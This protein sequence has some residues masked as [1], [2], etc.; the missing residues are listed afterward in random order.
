MHIYIYI[1]R[2]CA[3]LN[4]PISQSERSERSGRGADGHRCRSGRRGVASD[5]EGLR[6]FLSLAAAQASGASDCRM[7][8]PVKPKATR[9]PLSQNGQGSH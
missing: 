3:G 8:L 1:Y 4:Q 7:P 2:D 5:R 9:A 6:A